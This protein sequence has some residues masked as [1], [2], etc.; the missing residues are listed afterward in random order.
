LDNHFTLHHATGIYKQ[1]TL[2]ALQTLLYK[3]VHCVSLVCD[4][5]LQHK[6]RPLKNFPDG[7]VGSLVNPRQFVFSH[8]IIHSSLTLEF[9]Y[10]K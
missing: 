2:E 5:T 6:L 9:G 1:I 4:F 3:T 10:Q 8:R 7:R